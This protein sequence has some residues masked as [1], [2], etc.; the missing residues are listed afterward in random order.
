MSD[1][2]T[3]RIVKLPPMPT[4]DKTVYGPARTVYGHYFSADRMREYAYAARADADAE[5]D[6]LREELREARRG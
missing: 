1:L 2:P 5:I 3:A 6:R 4:P